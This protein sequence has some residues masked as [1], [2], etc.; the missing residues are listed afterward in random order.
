M[1]SEAKAEEAAWPLRAWALMILGGLIA[2]AIQQ[3]ITLPE[4]GWTWGRRLVSAASM[5][6]GIAGLSFGL[7]WVKGRLRPAIAIALLCGAVA[8]GSFVWNGLPEE[9]FGANGWH[10][11]CGVLASAFMLTL[12]QAGQERAVGWPVG[13]SI[14]ALNVWTRK[15]IHY[16][17]VYGHLWNNA[18]LLGLSGFFALFVIGVAHL[19]GEMFWLVRLDFLRMA[20]SQPWFNALLFG[21][22][23][24]AALGLLRDRQVIIAA[25]QRMAML[26]LSVLAPVVA[27]A[28]LAFLAALPFTGLAPLWD[29]GRT[30][31]IMLV[32]ALLVLFLLNVVVGERAADES[33]SVVLGASAVVLGLVLLPMV[34][35][36]TFSTWLRIA[37]YGFSPD[38][39]WALTF[40]IVMAIIA[41][42]YLVAILGGHGWFARLRRSNL[43]LIFMLA[44]VALLLSTPLLGFERIAAAQQLARLDDGRVSAEAFD[45]KALQFDYGPPG[46]AVLKRLASSSP[47][48]IVRDYAAKASRLEN[49]WADAPNATELAA[50]TPLTERLTIL[51]APVPLD[52]GLRN[53]L[54]HDDACGDGADK[55]VLRYVPGQDYAVVIR[56]PTGQCNRCE[57]TIALLQ[58]TKLGWSSN[59]TYLATAG[60][61]AAKAAAVRAGQVEMR[62]VQQRQLFINGKPAG[63]PIALENAAEP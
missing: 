46:R 16:P 35:I 27:I 56:A 47:N 51:P 1:E 33:R 29:T 14:A 54:L 39:L 11:F 63:S 34:V 6:L 41:L 45:Y 50:G 55:C 19:L 17:A 61:S 9:A 4:Q 30:T 3:M 22:S 48:T 20:L 18:L 23:I 2:F 44:G 57:E 13:W 8:G 28:I 32:G 36:A 26:V 52:A 25:L 12:F 43:A 49:R 31:P 40:D 60:D 5:S 62:L 53:R 21:A 59:V 15:T 38:R 37:Q 24:G 10:L 42:A 58:R 7:A